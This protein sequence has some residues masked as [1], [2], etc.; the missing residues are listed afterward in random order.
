MSQSSVI[1]LLHSGV[2]AALL[3]SMSG[4]IM[5]HMKYR[6]SYYCWI[7]AIDMT[8]ILPKWTS[9]TLGEFELDIDQF[10]YAATIA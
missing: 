9:I 5:Q 4:C 7:N 6:T 10:V 2:I 8:T 1:E 3:G